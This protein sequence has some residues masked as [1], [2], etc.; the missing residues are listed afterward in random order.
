MRLPAQPPPEPQKVAHV[1]TWEA[2]PDDEAERAGW[3][4]RQTTAALGQPCPAYAR[5]NADYATPAARQR[6]IAAADELRAALR[7]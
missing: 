3:F 1:S 4:I 6:V 2:E 5:R 7:R